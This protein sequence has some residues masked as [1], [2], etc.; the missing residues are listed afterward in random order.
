[1]VVSFFLKTSHNITISHTTSKTSKMQ[2]EIPAKGTKQYLH[3]NRSHI[4]APL[5]ASSSHCRQVKTQTDHT[6]SNSTATLQTEDQTLSNASED[7]QDDM[8]VKFTE[9]SRLGDPD[10]ESANVAKVDVNSSNATATLQET[11][12]LSLLI[13]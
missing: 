9:S 10:I 5:T 13:I 7:T 8:T 2:L 3:L 12:A 6:S 4:R 1:M 11:P